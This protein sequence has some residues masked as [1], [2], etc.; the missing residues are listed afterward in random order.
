MYVLPQAVAQAV[1]KISFE[2]GGLENF[3]RFFI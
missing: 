1:D 3:P 2:F